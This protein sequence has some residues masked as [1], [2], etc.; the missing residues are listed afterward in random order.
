MT[1][2][3]AAAD[4]LP[5]ALGLALFVALALALFVTAEEDAFIYYRY[6]LNWVHGKGLVFNPGDPV[7]GY[8][9]PLWMALVGALASLRLDLPRAVPA[10][11]IACGAATIVGTWWLAR[12]LGLDRFGRLAAALGL[13]LSYPFILWSR[14]GLE[15]PLYSLLLVVAAGLYLRAELPA[16]PPGAGAAAV[17]PPAERLA[18]RLAGG[19]TL[20]LVSLARPE[21]VLLVP[22]VA[23][24]RLA[25]RDWRG[26]VRYTLPAALG[27]GAYL[28]WRLRTYGRLV[29]NTSVKIDPLQIGRSSEQLLGYL[30]LLGVLPLLL[31]VIAWLD[32]GAGRR[33][34]RRLG[35]LLGMIAVLSLL[36]HLLAGGDYRMEMRFLVPT[37]PI[38]LVACWRSAAQLAA[39]GW[40]PAR[41]LARQPARWALLALLL[42]GSSELLWLNLPSAGEL[43]QL[44]RQWRDPFADSANW[45][46]AIALWTVRHVPDGSLV[47]FGQMGKVP[48]YATATG[49]DIRFLDTLGLVDRQV[50]AI[51]RFDHKLAA[52]AHRLLAGRSL[53][54][55]SAG[56]DRELAARLAANL[57]AR[58]PDFIFVEA[59]QNNLPTVEAIVRHPG[60]AALYAQ[61]GEIPGPPYVGV[62][63]LRAAARAGRPLGH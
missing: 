5:L 38:L 28:A 31:P 16:A 30:V 33:E 7:E 19:A 47:A 26:A 23:L 35:F 34:R 3:S 10:L 14:S 41:L 17:P 63:A 60:F 32:G 12:G 18:L 61:V 22:L 56:V 2:G 59:Y 11:G 20:A 15:T 51:Y 27:Y 29:P 6:A 25:G 42:F 8:S 53:A 43:P 40:R 55:A 52:L 1:A 48:Y 62:Y 24:D 54:A 9:S 13:A 50:A 58:R 4:A 57:L 45:R 36:F 46:V 44:A 39:S 37:L 49:H 21:G